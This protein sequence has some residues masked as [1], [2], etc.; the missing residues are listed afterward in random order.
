MFA[1]ST[2]VGGVLPPITLAVFVAAMVIRIR[3]WMKL[4]RPGMTL[5]PTPPG[6]KTWGVLKETLLFPSLFRGDRTLWVLSWVFHAMLAL[7]FIGHI[8]VVMDFPAL[9]SA[10]HIDG[11]TM[12]A[13]VGGTAGILMMTMT[14]LL[15]FRRALVAR[16]SQISGVGDYFALFLVL[17]VVL[18]GNAMRFLGHFDLAQS[19][20]FFGAFVTFSAAPVPQNPW[21]LLHLF[22]AQMLILYIPFSKI[23]HFG[24]V[25]F[26]QVAVRG[27]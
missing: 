19:R 13:V 27:S 11:D 12:S 24:G 9:W 2:L 1:F 15:L 14:A 18:T 6:G 22:L 21:F 10:L 26:T 3:S 5:F 23:L 16:V 17:A 7:V 4:P 25:F 20:A 8:R